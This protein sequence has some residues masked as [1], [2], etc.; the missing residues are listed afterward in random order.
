MVFTKP[1]TIGGFDRLFRIWGCE[2]RILHVINHL[3]HI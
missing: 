3:K 2:C 1:T